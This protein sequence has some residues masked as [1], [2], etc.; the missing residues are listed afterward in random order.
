M[1]NMPQQ[2]SR[3]TPEQDRKP[4][5]FDRFPRTMREAYGYHAGL[6]VAK[7]ETYLQA[8]FGALCVLAV[9][10]LLGLVAWLAH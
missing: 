1:R 2:M 7:E 8:L 6:H 5:R 9:P 3:F 10:A 4:Y